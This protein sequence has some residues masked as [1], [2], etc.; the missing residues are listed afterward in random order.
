[1]I[2]EDVTDREAHRRRLS[3]PD[4]YR[5]AA[6][7]RCGGDVLHV[8]DYVE[9][10]GYGEP[11]PARPAASTG[12]PESGAVTVVRYRCISEECGATWRVLPAFLVRHLWYSWRAVE[13]QTM[14]PS[15]PPPTAAVTTTP[16]PPPRRPGA[17]TVERWLGR[18]ASAARMIVQLFAS[19]GTE[20]LNV[21][22]MQLGLDATR[23]Q[24]VIAYDAAMHVPDGRRLSALA[25]HVHRLAPGIRLM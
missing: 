16:R 20:L 8:H 19:V 22:S 21:I 2:A 5:L 23:E 3:D 4:G 25:G 1:M 12:A 14:M 10:V 15:P 6:C 11:H 18:L 9:R 13:A 24:I 17:R 7:P